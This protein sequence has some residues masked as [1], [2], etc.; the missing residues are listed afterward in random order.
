MTGK[1][2]RQVLTTLCS[3]CRAINRLLVSTIDI[4]RLSKNGEVS[5]GAAVT[6]F[7]TA[8]RR[9]CRLHLHPN[10]AVS[11]ARPSMD[12]ACSSAQNEDTGDA[13][14]PNTERRR[15]GMCC[16]V[17]A[18]CKCPCAA[19]AKDR[20][21]HNRTLVRESRNTTEEAGISVASSADHR[22]RKDPPRRA[23]TLTVPTPP[24]TP[25]P[26]MFTVSR[27]RRHHRRRSDSRHSVSNVSL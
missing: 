8:V 2:Y 23:A 11:S 12:T 4:R 27:Q 18:G 1:L 10:D 19:S 25:S 26:E 17:S 15:L 16:C 13:K 24:S 5:T 21:E 20:S 9:P 14:R 7:P 6:S 3:P 22:K